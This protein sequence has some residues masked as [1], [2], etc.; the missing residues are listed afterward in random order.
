MSRQQRVKYYK[1]TL[2]EK[3]EEKNPNKNIMSI[4]S[5]NTSKQAQKNNTLTVYHIWHMW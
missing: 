2:V 3:N 5:N 1:M 4:L